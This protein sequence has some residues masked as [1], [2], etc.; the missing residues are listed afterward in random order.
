MQEKD[1]LQSLLRSCG[2]L[3]GLLQEDES[4]WFQNLPQDIS[5]QTIEEKIQART[6]AKANKDY[7]L[8]DQIRRDLEAIGI[9]LED[10]PQ[11]TTWR[12]KT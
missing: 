6:A 12:N 7:T 9:L 3:L 10:T 8:A 11:G 1:H 5:V 2:S 4:S